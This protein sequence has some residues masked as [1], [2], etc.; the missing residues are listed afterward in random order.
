MVIKH[1]SSGI[2]ASVI[3]GQVYHT[4]YFPRH[5]SFVHDIFYLNLPVTNFDA[6][7]ALPFCSYNGF[8]I[9]S[10]TDKDYGFDGGR[11]SLTHF[12]DENIRARGIED[13]CNGEKR[14]I[15]VPRFMGYGFNP[16]SFWCCF[17]ADH[18]LR[19]V[20]VEVHNTFF[21]RHCYW[22]MKEDKSEILS[23]DMLTADKIFHVSP[24][25][26]VKGH[27]EFR[28]KVT[29][30]NFKI[31]INYK[32]DGKEILSTGITGRQHSLEAR[33][34]WRW[35]WRY[36]FGTMKII[37]LIHWHALRLWLKKIKYFRK[38]PPPRENVS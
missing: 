38:P 1:H 30:E 24:F 12:I 4:R 3:E 33:D 27:Y 21:E 18:R 31:V 9:F 13:I 10:I 37:T 25:M 8:N 6:F 28:F 22:L 34:P 5:H 19:A 2:G 29:E 36:P 11:S 26:P 32:I 16:V 17:D 15:T 20:L 14:L 35:L 7:H 23:S